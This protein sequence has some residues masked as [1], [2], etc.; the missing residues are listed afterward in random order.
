MENFTLHPNS[1]PQT[2]LHLPAFLHNRLTLLTMDNVFTPD[3]LNTPTF[4]Q[5][6]LKK[7]LKENAIIEVNNL[8]ASKPLHDISVDEVIEIG[9]RYNVDLKAM[10]IDQLRALYERYV[11]RCF[12]DNAL[13]ADE[14]N[15]LNYL[16]MLLLLDE[17]D[18]SDIYEVYATNAF[19]TNLDETLSHGGIDDEKIAFL[20]KL[21][22]SLNLPDELAKK[23]TEEGKNIFLE[24]QLAKITDDER[25]SPEEME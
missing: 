1:I 2:L 25:V 22:Q 21:Q 5:R 19:K 12:E 14:A 18:I 16:R 10:F 15:D 9:N 23:I 6:L 7:P 17:G 11:T 8:L 13:S 20:H 24:M 4:F 3:L